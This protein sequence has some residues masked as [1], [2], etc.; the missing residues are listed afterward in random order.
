VARPQGR[1]LQKVEGH[2]RIVAEEGENDH[3][4][5]VRLRA[6]I[7]CAQAITCRII[8]YVYVDV[9]LAIQ[10]TA[11]LGCFFCIEGSLF[12]YTRK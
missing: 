7:L 4:T 1:S 9:D 12:F 10:A 8:L 5:G 3:R 11:L 2:E 6:F